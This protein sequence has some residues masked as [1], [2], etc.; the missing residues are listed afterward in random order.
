MIVLWPLTNV[1]VIKQ[2]Q[3]IEEL[4]IVLYIGYLQ[5]IRRRQLRG[6]MAMPATI[7]IKIASTTSTG[8][9]KIEHCSMY[10]L[11][12]RTPLTV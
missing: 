5:Q 10:G 1:M 6:E 7:G 8:L 9:V 3:H 2:K 11:V 12:D 4:S